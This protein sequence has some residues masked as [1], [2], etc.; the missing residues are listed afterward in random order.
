MTAKCNVGSW[1]REK[2]LGKTKGKVGLQLIINFGGGN[3]RSG[4]ER[5]KREF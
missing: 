1:N 4:E 3:V 5:A 2:T